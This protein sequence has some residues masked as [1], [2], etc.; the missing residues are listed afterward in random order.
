MVC[1][2][3]KRQSRNVLAKEVNEPIMSKNHEH[4]HNPDWL[5]MADKPDDRRRIGEDTLDMI[6]L[7][8]AL[9]VIG[10]AMAKLP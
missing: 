4:N 3:F 6:L 8:V 9:T 2:A 1:G 10:L 7:I 5:P